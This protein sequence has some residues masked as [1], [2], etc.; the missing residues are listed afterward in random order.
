MKIPRI[1][2]QIWLGPSPLPEQDAAYV[3]TWKQ[4]HPDW[5]HRLWTED[6]LAGDTGR[7]ETRERLRVPAERSD[8][9]RLELVVQALADE[10]IHL[11]EHVRADDAGQRLDQAFPLVAR[12]KLDQVGD[13]GGVQRL[14]QP[15]RGFVVAVIDGIENPADE[16]RAQPVFFVDG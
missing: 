6:D 8:L 11:R 3:E 1:I 15:P 4:L 14:D 16:F 13:V 2:H 10:L 5:E 9:L 12:G 7:P